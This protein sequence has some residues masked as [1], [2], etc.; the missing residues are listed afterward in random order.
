MQG[1]VLMIVVNVEWIW[2]GRVII[3]RIKG[4]DSQLYS[5]NKILLHEYFVKERKIVNLA[6]ILS[7]H[8]QN[9]KKNNGCLPYLSLKYFYKNRLIKNY[10]KLHGCFWLLSW[11]LK[12][13]GTNLWRP[14]KLLI[15]T[16]MESLQE[17][18]LLSASCFY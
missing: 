13:K 18:K 11:L 15:Q 9:I 14:S 6:Q 3:L 12:K 4:L 2:G 5:W 7:F 17:M 10:K 1:F 8:I 16:E